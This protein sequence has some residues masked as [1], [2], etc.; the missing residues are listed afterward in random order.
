LPAVLS[1][2]GALIVVFSLLHIARA[3][4]ALQGADFAGTWERGG[5]ATE[6]VTITVSGLAA[7]IQGVGVTQGASGAISG[8]TVSWGDSIAGR[9]STLVTE[10]QMQDNDGTIWTRKLDEYDQ[11]CRHERYPT[12]SAPIQILDGRRT[13]KTD[14]RSNQ[15]HRYYYENRDI[16]TLN[17]PAVNRKLIISLEACRGIVYIFVRKTRRC[18]PD[19]YSCISLTP[20]KEFRRPQDCKWTHFMSIIDGSRD[21]T[22]T[23]FEIEFTTTRYY[24]SVFSADNSEYTLTVLADIGA[25]PRPGKLGRVY[26]DQQG[27]LKVSLGWYE[28][29]Y[30]PNN[31]IQGGFGTGTLMYIVYAAPLLDTDKRVSSTCFLRPQKIMNTYCGLERNTDEDVYQVDPTAVC[32]DGY[33]N[34]TVDWVMP[35]RRYVFNIVAVS[36]LNFKSAYAGLI[37]R[38]QYDVVRQATSDNTLKAIGVVAGGSLGM[39][40]VIYFL[41]LK[42]YG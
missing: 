18:Y 21:G 36:R 12:V 1:R 25:F 27:E 5:S 9:I 31:L 8:T 22:P 32:Q 30:V 6:T 28:A 26:G 29:T 42:L 16:Q 40:I 14:I 24:M 11:V 33:C 15:T 20:G 13:E 10:N 35:E 34:V 37:M 39:V 3:Q 41:M 23:F 2:L 38:T 17:Q 7:T 4:E 19:P